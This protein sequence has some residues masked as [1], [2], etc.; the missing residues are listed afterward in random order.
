MVV[1]YG[2]ILAISRTFILTLNKILENSVFF[3]VVL[4]D[5]YLSVSFSTK[6]MC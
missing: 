4:A 1:P 5:E 6:M 2:W 3:C